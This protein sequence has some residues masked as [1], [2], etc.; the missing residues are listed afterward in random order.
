M[1]MTGARMVVK[2]LEAEG[3][4]VA[5]GI[6]GGTVVTLYDALYDAQFKHVLVRH[7]QAACHAADGYARASG[8]TGVCIATSGPGAT[9]LVTGIANAAMDS[10][11]LVV[12]TGQ[13][14]TSL[15]GTDAFQE[16]D[17]FG[18]TLPMV[19]H[20][21]FVKNTEDL[22]RAIRGAFHI[23]GS[24]RPGPVLVDIPADVQRASG[25]FAYPPEVSFPGYDPKG[26][27]NLA[28]LDLALDALLSASRPVLIAGGGVILGGA[29]D[30]LL[31]LAEEQG[32]P[33]VNSLMGKGAFPETHP[34]SLGL[35][36]MHGMPWANLAVSGADL[37]IG[38]GTRFCE[39]S[40]G[41]KDR[42]APK[43][44]ILHID[45]DPAEIDKNIPATYR[46]V[47]DAKKVLDLLLE[48]TKGKCRERTKAGREA[49][50]AAIAEWRRAYPL[51]STFPREELAPWDILAA[52]RERAGKDMPVVTEVGQHQMW[53]AQHWTTEIPRN[54]ITSGGLGTMG[55]GLP[56]AVGIS[57]ARS[58]PRGPAPVVCI[59]GDGSF[60]MNC[61]ELDTIARYGLPVKI[62]LFNNS[63]L[64][65]VRQWQQL[66]WNERYSFT[67]TEGYD[68]EKLAG[69]FDIPARR[70]DSNADLAETASW[71]FD[72]EGPAVADFRIPQKDLV[73][74]M[75][76]AGAALDEFLHTI[77]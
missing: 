61:Q 60:L 53:A 52:L 55:F 17:I 2:A 7:E 70:V 48:G 18:A 36:G 28:D 22:Q 68:V 72:T 66:F 5:F 23:A 43:A 30:S 75:V 27:E 26:K 76:P 56:A 65:M 47:G 41:R 74:P 21:F 25:T 20:S 71:L 44:R 42:Y 29:W 49:W 77:A 10:V 11:P 31:R 8:K 58:T 6:P 16:A 32:I 24:G 39:R 46:L 63:S 38:V 33:V 51:Q 64:G 3:V 40:T 37:V 35:V 50:H 1:T 9:N 15:I 45:R 73:L 13:V 34:L 54:F 57:L 67:R 4:E 62:A 19:K 14:L 59:A 12:L 69:A